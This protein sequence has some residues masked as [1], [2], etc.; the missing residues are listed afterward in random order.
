[1][2]KN[3]RLSPEMR[4]W[5]EV[6]CGP[7]RCCCQPHAQSHVCCSWPAGSRPNIKAMAHWA[8]TAPCG[9]PCSRSVQLQ[10]I[11]PSARL[12]TAVRAS[13][14]ACLVGRLPAA[15]WSVAARQRRGMATGAQQQDGHGASGSAEALSPSPIASSSSPSPAAAAAELSTSTPASSSSSSDKVSTSGAGAGG[16]A[17]GQAGAAAAA[18][19]QPSP[20]DLLQLLQSLATSLL[21]VASAALAWLRVRCR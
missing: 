20:P 17:A 14:G 18:A 13:R 7:G 4:V 6:P 15:A 10:H 8:W 21:A 11:R 9:L 2:P 16:A 3:P 12:G 1:M 19:A 5:A